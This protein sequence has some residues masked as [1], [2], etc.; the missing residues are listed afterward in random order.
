LSASNCE[1]GS[2]LAVEQTEAKSR[3]EVLSRLHDAARRLRSKLGESLASVQ[4]HD[5][6]LEQATTSSLEALQAFSQAQRAF[7]TQGETAA[8]PLFERAL[9]LDPY[10]ALALSDLGTLY[11]NLDEE[12][13]CANYAG[14]AYAFRDRVSERERFVIESNYFMYVSGELERA[15]QVFEEWKRLYPRILYPYINAALVAGNLG[16]NDVAL[17]NDLNAYEIKKDAAIV[18]RNLSCQEVG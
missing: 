17:A 7:R 9:K 6:P 1:D 15:A 5:I 3:E 12:A 10:F 16:R 2:S 8:I 18:Y 4:K 11:C 13:P 14:E